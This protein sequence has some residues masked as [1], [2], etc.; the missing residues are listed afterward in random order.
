M[1]APFHG[2][3]TLPADN[4]GDPTA[5]IPPEPSSSR[6]DDG[7]QSTLKRK[8]KKKKQTVVSD[9][10]SIDSSSNCSSAA[11]YLQKGVKISR[12]PKRIRVGPQTTGRK[13]VGLSDVDALGLPLGM[14]IAAVVAQVFK[15]FVF[16][17]KKSKVLFLSV[18]WFKVI[19][20]LHVF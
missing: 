7:P 2:H 11:S 17:S 12:N 9:S 15:L 16:L 8:I 18:L 19:N 13:N 5:A 20:R 4:A 6:T 14:S 10:A 1:D 3:P